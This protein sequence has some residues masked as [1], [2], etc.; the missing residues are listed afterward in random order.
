MCFKRLSSKKRGV[1][2]FS[3]EGEQKPWYNRDRGR[4]AP[5]HRLRH[6]YGFIIRYPVYGEDSTGIRFEPWHIRY[7]G[8][9]HATIIQKNRLTL[10]EYILSMKE[11]QWYAAQGYLFCRQRGENGLSLPADFSSALISDDNT[12]CYILTVTP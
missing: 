4:N 12:G 10:E 6:E 3:I 9:P 11:G 7:V 2:V 8:Q 5:R 1:F